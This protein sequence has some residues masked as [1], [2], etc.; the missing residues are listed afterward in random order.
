MHITVSKTS[1]QDNVSI[2][3]ESCRG[4]SACH[5]ACKGVIPK[6]N[7]EIRIP[8]NTMTSNQIQFIYKSATKTLEWLASLPNICNEAS[9]KD[10]TNEMA[11]EKILS[12]YLSD[13]QQLH[14]PCTQYA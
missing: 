2:L 4:D 11:E 6:K 5:N 3:V 10:Q 7:I 1:T 14:M 12:V 9:C 8:T 13:C